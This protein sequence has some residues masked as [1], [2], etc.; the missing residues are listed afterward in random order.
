MWKYSIYIE[1]DII[2]GRIYKITD[3]VTD[4]IY[5]GSC[6]ENLDSRMS[7]HIDK[8][9]SQ[10]SKLYTHMRNI[11][12][13]HFKMKL[14]SHHV[15]NNIKELRTLEQ[16]EINKYNPII[17]LNSYNAD[18]KYNELV[19]IVKPIIDELVNKVFEIK[20]QDINAEN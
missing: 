2:I 17:L 6:I 16:I 20:I 19:K 9:K 7:T 11:G 5:I 18:T 15:V 13:N 1:N 8:L 12:V 3:D 14:I 4:K 10:N